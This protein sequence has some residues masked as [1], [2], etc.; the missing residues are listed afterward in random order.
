MRAKECRTEEQFDS[1]R[2]SRVQRFIS[3]PESYPSGDCELTGEHGGDDDRGQGVNPMATQTRKKTAPSPTSVNGKKG[4]S[5]S[6]NHSK[7]QVENQRRTGLLLTTD[8][9]ELNGYWSGGRGQILRPAPRW[10]KASVPHPAP[11]NPDVSRCIGMNRGG[12]ANES[13]FRRIEFWK[14]C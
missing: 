2:E 8:E 12:T 11:M 5:R 7:S 9:E 4:K 1:W 10:E 13:A 3:H 14:A 6:V